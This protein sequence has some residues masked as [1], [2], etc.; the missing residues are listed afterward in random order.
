MPSH[1]QS[2][3]A[4]DSMTKNIDFRRS[5]RKYARELIGLLH[6][7]RAVFYCTTLVDSLPIPIFTSPRC[8]DLSTPGGVLNPMSPSDRDKE[9][10][11]LLRESDTHDA[12]ARRAK[13]SG[14]MS[15][16]L[17]LKNLAEDLNEQAHC[18]DPEHNAPAWLNG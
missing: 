15:E 13:D 10:E 9:V 3:S 16:C 6:I 8:P 11:R 1:R 7:C 17:R 12:N 4:N 2:E 18:I 14:F 5:P